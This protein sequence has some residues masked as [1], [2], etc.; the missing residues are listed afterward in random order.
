MAEPS[1]RDLLADNVELDLEGDRATVSVALWAA[2]LEV[3]EHAQLA[4]RELVF[5]PGSHEPK[6]LADALRGLRIVTRL[7]HARAA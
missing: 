5:R 6:R 3:A 2:L 4:E 1:I 7:V